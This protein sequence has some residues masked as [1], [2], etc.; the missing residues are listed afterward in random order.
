M[1]SKVKECDS[2]EGS[3]FETEEF[4]LKRQM[5]T[6]ARLP[7]GELHACRVGSHCPF[8]IPNDDRVMVCMYSG[9]E[10]GPEHTDEH[11]DINGGNGKKTGDP[12]IN[13]G[14]PVNGKWTK[15]ADP[16]QASRHAFEASKNFCDD[17]TFPYVHCPEDVSKL[18]KGRQKRSALCVGEEV[19]DVGVKR[20]RGGKKNTNRVETRINLVAEAESVILKMVDHKQ[21]SSYKQK[22]RDGKSDR[23]CAA[24]DPRMMDES[25]VFNNALKRYVK[26][27][28]I[29]EDAPSLDTIHNLSLMAR[30]VSEQAKRS[31]EET[32]A[33]D[34]VRTVKFRTNCSLLIVSLWRAA[35]A[36]PYMK[37]A[38]R[39]TD[40]YRPFVC[41]A[42]YALKR[43]LNLP[44]GTILLPQCPQ[45]ALAL[46]VLRGTGGNSVAKTLHSSSHRGMCTLSRCIASVPVSEHQELFADV[47]RV[48][49]Q[50]ASHRFSKWDV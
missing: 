31:E 44:N 12:D 8:L 26:N 40:A 23:R 10:H 38:K 19:E 49:V 25:F 33:S 20:N 43:G 48:A 37:N 24:V 27:C 15:R 16:V 5:P 21:A 42:L 34:A 32:L 6:L 28:T 30:A 36:T 18:G 22:A 47:A 13:S 29:S 45:L 4:A 7:T 39:G 46:P 41:G 1:T 35:C 9:L 14:E 11:F 3:D 2:E 50:F 17:G